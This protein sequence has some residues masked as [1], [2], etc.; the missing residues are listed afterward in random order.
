MTRV[1]PDRLCRSTIIDMDLESEIDR[2]YQLPLDQFTPAR[3][4]LAK[5]LAGAPAQQVKALA[6]P[7]LAAWTVNQLYWTDRKTFDG[8]IEA[9]ARLRSAHRATI[10]G[11][12]AWRKRSNE[13]KT[14]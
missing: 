14:P 11:R 13:H 12:K 6:K 7:A 3:N 10:E 2:L 5:D 8:L 1:L 9:A 4:A